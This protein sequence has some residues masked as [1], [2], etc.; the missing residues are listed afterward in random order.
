MR[1]P[2]KENGEALCILE[3]EEL[4]IVEKEGKKGQPSKD[5]EA[6]LPGR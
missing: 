2:Y 3:E 6:A 5:V 4:S 1:V